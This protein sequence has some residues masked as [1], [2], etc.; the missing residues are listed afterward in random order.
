MIIAFFDIDHTII[1]STSMERIFFKY[2]FSKSH[3]KVTDVLYTIAFILHHIFDASG[4]RMRSKRPYLQGKSVALM[5]ALATQCFYEAILPLVS[6]E[7]AAEIGRHKDAGHR[8]ILLSG[9]LEMLAGSLSQYVG[10]DESIA[11]RPEVADGYFTGRIIPPIPYGEGKRE[12]LISYAREYRIDLKQC[13]AYGD[14][15]SDMGIFE[16]VGNPCVVN[17]GRR[18][19]AIA[20]KRGWEIRYW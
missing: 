4:L 10:A 17:P 16:S 20:K 3:I 5:G 8:I 15:L 13:F 18:L 6:I 11:C 1:R 2:L 7:A 19:S 14:S 9:T 12:I